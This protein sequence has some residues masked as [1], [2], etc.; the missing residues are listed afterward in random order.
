MKKILFLAIMFVGFGLGKAQ[1][2][3]MHYDFGK[4]RK[5]ITTTV[6]MFRPD[7]FGSTFFF[8]DFDYGGDSRNVDGVSLAYMEIARGLKFWDNPFE[9]HVEYNGGM[10]RSNGFAGEINNAYLLGGHY[11]WN[12]SDFSRVFT[13]Q[14]MYKYIQDRN[15]ASFQITGVW[16]MHFFNQ[17]MTFSGFAD[18][19]MEKLPQYEMDNKFVFLT[20]PQLWYNATKNFSI[21]TEIEMSSNF[22][23][24][25]DFM[26]NPTIGAKWTF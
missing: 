15:D 25:K 12:N 1:N 8:I 21:G 24:E 19:W 20:E 3:Q 17:K 13:L 23:G 2:V 7:Q 4:D 10:F 22:S 26:I 14:A 18:L 5:L 11:T 9:L 6:E 16:A